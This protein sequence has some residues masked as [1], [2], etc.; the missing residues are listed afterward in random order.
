MQEKINMQVIYVYYK[1]NDFDKAITAEPRRLRVRKGEVKIIAM[2]EKT[3]EAFDRLKNK[4]RYFA[5][6]RASG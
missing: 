2:P 3:K 5:G 6:G 1:N 4:N